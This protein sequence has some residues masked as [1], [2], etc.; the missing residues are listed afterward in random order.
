MIFNYKLNLTGQIYYLISKFQLTEYSFNYDNAKLGFTTVC[1]KVLGV[2]YQKFNSLRWWNYLMVLKNQCSISNVKNLRQIARITSH[3]SYFR[4][5]RIKSSIN[6]ICNLKWLICLDSKIIITHM[7]Q[8][9][10]RWIWITQCSDSKI[11]LYFWN[12][13][14]SLCI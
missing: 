2:I 10:V 7:K 5:K 1:D 9:L 11:K 12:K 13:I 14:Q 6:I 8:Q 3:I 4:V